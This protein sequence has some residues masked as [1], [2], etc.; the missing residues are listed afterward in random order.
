MQTYFIVL[1][2]I[3]V[4]HILCFLNKRKIYGN[5]ESSKSIDVIFPTTFA[6]FLPLCH[7]WVVFTIF[8][9]FCYYYIV[10]MACDH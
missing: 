5:P 10:M 8:Q 4:L 7:I 1:C 3:E 2:F 9:F 6:P